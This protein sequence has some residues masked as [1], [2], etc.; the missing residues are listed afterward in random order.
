M[1]AR[2]RKLFL[3]VHMGLSHQGLTLLAQES[4]V[5]LEAMGTDDLLMF[6]N[7]LGDKMKLLGAQGRVVGYLKMPG[8]Q[9]IMKEALRYIPATFG[10]QGFDYD[11]ACRRAL[12][13][14]LGTKEIS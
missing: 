4:G 13:E 8:K 6:M 5:K 9:R 11:A 10:A 3:D 14:R 12:Q 1:S 2:I 7:R